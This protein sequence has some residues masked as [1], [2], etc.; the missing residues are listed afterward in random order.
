[1]FW[2]AP[3]TW[4]MAY[5]I[6]VIESH[7]IWPNALH[8][9]HCSRNVIPQKS[10]S[11][12]NPSHDSSQGV[13]ETARTRIPRGAPE[14]PNLDPGTGPRSRAA[15]PPNPLPGYPLSL[16]GSPEDFSFLTSREEPSDGFCRRLRGPRGTP[17]AQGIETR[18]RN[19]ILRGNSEAG[20]GD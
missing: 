10:K 18:V 6:W 12:S 19:E 2:V 14:N 15:A 1:M 8:K 5:M 7:N 16:L 17:R 13:T 11:G 4:H 3:A 9:W 20:V